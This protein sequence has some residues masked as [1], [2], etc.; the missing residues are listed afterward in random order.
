MGE[1]KDGAIS[2]CLPSAKTFVVHYP[3]YPSSASRAI[4][5]L[6]GSEGILKVWPRSLAFLAVSF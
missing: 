4:E 5:T 1:I 2:G 6:G 3:G